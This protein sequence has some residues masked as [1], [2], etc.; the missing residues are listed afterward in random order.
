MM[1]YDTGLAPRAPGVLPNV[2]TLAPVDNEL[3]DIDGDLV[4]DSPAR[5]HGL[6][7]AA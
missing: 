4:A 3:I 7:I 1:V 6:A 2:A 5:G